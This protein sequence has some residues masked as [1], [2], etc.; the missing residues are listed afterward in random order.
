MTTPI[1]DGPDAA[2]A[3]PVET[4]GVPCQPEANLHVWFSAQ[5]K[6]GAPC[7]CGARQ[8][9]VPPPVEQK[10]SILHLKIH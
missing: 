8:W 6:Q 10:S 2:R 3:A 1:S 5:Q 4:T 7:K 9:G